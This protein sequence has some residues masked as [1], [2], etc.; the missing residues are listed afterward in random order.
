MKQLTMQEYEL[1][2]DKLKN[3]KLSKKE[4]ARLIG[5][6][7]SSITRIDKGAVEKVR[8]I[9]E[10]EFPIRQTTAQRNAKMYEYFNRT[11]D[12]EATALKFDLSPVTVN[13]MVSKEEWLNIGGLWY[14]KTEIEEVLRNVK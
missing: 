5:C 1:V 13:N 7:A 2:V 6:N 4:I 11:R 8:K 14:R 10:G 9:Y 3:S 12:L